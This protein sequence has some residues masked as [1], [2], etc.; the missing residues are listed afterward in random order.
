MG[1][2]DSKSDMIRI[3]QDLGIT[4]N[5]LQN[6]FIQA[7][8]NADNSFQFVVQNHLSNIII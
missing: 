5:Q 7:H 8:I 1:K 2:N 4:V 6:F 3:N